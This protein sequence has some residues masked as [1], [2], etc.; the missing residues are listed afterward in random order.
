MD[1]TIKLTGDQAGKI[2]LTA[3]RMMLAAKL[4]MEGDVWASIVESM[5][6]QM[7][8]QLCQSE[9]RNTAKS[10]TAPGAPTKPQA[11]FAKPKSRPSIRGRSGKSITRG[12]NQKDY[13]TK[14]EWGAPSG[15]TSRSPWIER[16]Q[17]QPKEEK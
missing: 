16:A 14:G 2:L 11:A 17:P 13:P 7:E 6:E 1:Y 9:C 10:L 3:T 15:D 5:S 4:P 8:D 12:S